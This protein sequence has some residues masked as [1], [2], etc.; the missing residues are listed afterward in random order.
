MPVLTRALPR[1]LFLIVSCFALCVCLIN[2]SFYTRAAGQA[3]CQVDCTV[4]VP[5]S[6][7]VGNSVASDLRT[8][9]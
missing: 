4:T 6:A 8:G 5:D 1:Q 2:F 7:T 3:N 9:F